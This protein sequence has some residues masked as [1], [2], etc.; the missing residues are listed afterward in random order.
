MLNL[1]LFGPPGAGKGTQSVK[2]AEKYGLTHLSTGDIFRANIKG[3]TELGVTAKSFME[4][5]RLVPD[6]I[7]IGMLRAEVNKVSN[8]NGFIFDG[9]P[10]T[11]PQAVALDEL[12]KEF[13]TSISAVISLEVTDAELVERLKNRAHTSGRTDDADE[14]IIM[15]RIEVYKNETYPL[16]DYY[17]AQGKVKIV[18]GIG[19]IDKI[20]SQICSRIDAG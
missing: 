17:E 11:I 12:L 4:Q 9:F 19:E 8:P 15:K 18:E 16:K 3:G 20:F 13:N 14:N 6:E 5:G 7:T 1:I 10:R 2:V